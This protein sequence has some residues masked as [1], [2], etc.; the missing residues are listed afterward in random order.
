MQ[1]VGYLAVG[2]KTI[3]VGYLDVLE[4]YNGGWVATAVLHAVDADGDELSLPAAASTV[5]QAGVVPGSVAV[6][7]IGIQE[8]ESVSWVRTWPGF[9]VSVEP[10]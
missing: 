2:E 4:Q 10:Y 9:V 5:L 3:G 6:V 1:Y 8:G 7:G